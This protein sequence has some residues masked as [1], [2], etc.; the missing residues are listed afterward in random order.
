M[1]AAAAFSLERHLEGVGTASRINA[2]GC[3][4]VLKVFLDAHSRLRREL[5]WILSNGDCTQEARLEQI[6]RLHGVEVAERSR[7]WRAAVENGD[8]CVRHVFWQEKN[9]PWDLR[10]GQPDAEQLCME[11]RAFLARN[12]YL[13]VTD[14]PAHGDVVAYGWNLFAP[15]KGKEVFEHF[16]VIDGD[17]V[18]SKVCYVYRHPLSMLPQ[19][20]GNEAVFLR[21]AA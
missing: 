4:D 17:R 8:D 16:G 20:Y 13:P 14:G 10:R 19:M 11:T 3:R 9:E 6:G 21:K 1:N 12:G 5:E 15:E 18:K 2:Q 7:D